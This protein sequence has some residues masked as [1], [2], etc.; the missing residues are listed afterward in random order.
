MASETPSEV[1]GQ[2]YVRGSDSS[3][4]PGILTFGRRVSLRLLIVTPEIGDGVPA[5]L[6]AALD[7][8]QVDIVGESNA[9]GCI[10]LLRCAYTK[11]RSSNHY[12]RG[13]QTTDL[14]FQPT[15]IWAGP[16]PFERDD[17]F[18]QLTLSFSGIHGIIGTKPLARKSFVKPEEK[19]AIEHVLGDT[20]EVFYND[21]SA[22]HHVVALDDPPADVSF[23]S[24]YS[25]SGSW[26]EGDAISTYDECLVASREALV[27]EVLISIGAKIEKFLSFIGLKTI[28]CSSFKLARS[29][30]ENAPPEQFERLWYLGAEDGSNSVM[31]HEALASCFKEASAIKVALRRWLSP[32]EDEALARWLYLDSQD[33]SVISAGRFISVCQA[34]EIIGRQA[35]G[36][37]PF[38]KARFR[39]A[40]SKVADVICAELGP[41][42]DTEE[43]RNRFRQLVTSGNRFSFRD[44]IQ[45]FVSG[46]PPV[47]RNALLP[48][49]EAFIARLV[50]MR[51]LFVHME[52]QDLASE[53]AESHIGEMTYRL[54]ALFAAHQGAALGLN[55]H[56]VL[57]GLANSSIGRSA[58]HYIDRAKR[59][60]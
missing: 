32:S 30:G 3:S 46:I 11:R 47:L 1:L 15:E 17:S 18:T 35:K 55:P 56:R 57:S 43:Y 31:F 10:T 33:E 24:G 5:P 19:R 4:W 50:K 25:V 39:S 26:T 7:G 14:T 8:K 9:H 37:A 34:V 48:D 29:R 45:E 53:Q 12:F 52:S 60:G 23:G 40:A 54:L 28:R 41:D 38:D 20:F 44:H 51:N 58:N 22:K 36:G 27:G 59:R 49:Q 21:T 42:F 16:R 2:F 6:A 13:V